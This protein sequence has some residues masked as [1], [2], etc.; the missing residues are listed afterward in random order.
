[1]QDVGDGLALRRR[2]V[3]IEHKGNERLIDELGS[4]AAVETEE[5]LRLHL[6]ACGIKT[7]GNP[8]AA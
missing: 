6:G 5:E 8:L 7:S 3:R 1:M 2:A 4:N